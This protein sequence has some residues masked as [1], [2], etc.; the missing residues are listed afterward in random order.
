MKRAENCGESGAVSFG[1]A[2]SCRIRRC[3][4]GGGLGNARR[5]KQEGKEE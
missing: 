2:C 3:R 4:R 1:V 5:S